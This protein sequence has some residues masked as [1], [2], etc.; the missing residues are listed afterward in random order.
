MTHFSFRF[1]VHYFDKDPDEDKDHKVGEAEVLFIA[2]RHPNKGIKM[3]QPMSWKDALSDVGQD[4]EANNWGSGPELTANEVDR[5]TFCCCQCCHGN[6]CQG[7][8]ESICGTFPQHSTC[9]QFYTPAMF[10]AYHREGYRACLEAQ[11][12]E[13][14]TEPTSQNEYN[15]RLEEVVSQ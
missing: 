15:S 2:P 8:S 5:L 9:N 6:A 12:A 14:L 4:L 7:F 13:F 3:E 10:T 11:A 1:K